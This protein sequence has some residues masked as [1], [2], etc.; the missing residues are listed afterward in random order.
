MYK[1]SPRYCT[2]TTSTPGRVSVFVLLYFRGGCSGQTLDAFSLSNY[3][4]SSQ[5]NV[6]LLR[7]LR[8]NVTLFNCN[9]SCFSIRCTVAR[10]YIYTNTQTSTEGCISV[11]LV[12]KAQQVLNHLPNKATC[13]LTAAWKISYN[14]TV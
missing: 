11:R 7:G 5:K 14:N 1:R 9:T 2:T 13:Y 3:S 8:F 10:Q 6:T 4:S 12:T